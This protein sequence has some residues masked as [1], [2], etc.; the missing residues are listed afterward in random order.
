MWIVS[1]SINTMLVNIR[2]I[3]YFEF[4]RV[5]KNKTVKLFFDMFFLIFIFPTACSPAKDHI[6][7]NLYTLICTGYRQCEP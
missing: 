5:L 2:E 7:S 6:K 3:L 1:H 4:I